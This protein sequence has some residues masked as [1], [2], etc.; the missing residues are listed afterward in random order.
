MTDT[1]CDC[2]ENVQSLNEEI[3]SL[4]RQLANEKLRADTGWER[5]ESANIDRNTVRATLSAIEGDVQTE[6]VATGTCS[7]TIPVYFRRGVDD[8]GR[9]DVDTDDFEEAILAVKESLVERGTGWT[10]PVL[11]VINGGNKNG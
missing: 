6:V 9:I 7:A 3:L 10:H 4:H 5:Y 1:K 11:A 2:I 8:I